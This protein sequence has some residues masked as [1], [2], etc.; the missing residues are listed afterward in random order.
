MLRPLVRVFAFFLFGFI[1]LGVSSAHATEQMYKRE[2]NGCHSGPPTC[3][4]C[5]VHGTHVL[6]GDLA[7]LNLVATTDKTEYGVGDEITVT[8]SGGSRPQAEGW[9][10]VKLYDAKGVPLAHVKTELPATLTT[11]AYEGMTTL[12][13]SWIGFD[14]EQTGGTYGAPMGDTFGPGMRLSF[15]AGLHLNQPHIEE[16]VATNAFAVGGASAA[17]LD[18][19]ADATGSDDASSGGGG[20]LDL[21]WL[22]GGL[23][24]VAFLRRRAHWQKN[25]ASADTQRNKTSSAAPV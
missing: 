5:H 8:L 25:R 11:R 2:C 17:Q 10:G 12:Y 9:V 4:G 21:L 24:A 6:T 7:S 23:L 20:A 16:V 13:M 14:F 19:Q 18:M 22:L 15:M 1:S 3:N